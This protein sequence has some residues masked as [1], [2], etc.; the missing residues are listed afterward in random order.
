ML[1]RRRVQQERALRRDG[2]S[3]SRTHKR[4]IKA[5]GARTLFL[6]LEKIAESL[7]P[8]CLPLLSPIARAAPLQF[9][10]AQ[11]PTSLASALLRLLRHWMQ[12]ALPIALSAPGSSSCA[13][14]RKPSIEAR[15]KSFRRSAYPEPK[16]PHPHAEADSPDSLSPFSTPQQSQLALSNL[17][18]SSS[19]EI[20][21]YARTS[22]FMFII[23]RRFAIH[24]STYK[25]KPQSKPNI[26]LT[27]AVDSC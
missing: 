10:S 25:G 18:F 5:R 7:T 13:P 11:L 26:L 1:L 16:E 19:R 8:F 14:P 2:V 17:P 20:V 4:S 23:I 9:F 22:P 24:D 12:H 15:C 6:D 27:Q 3:A 21:S